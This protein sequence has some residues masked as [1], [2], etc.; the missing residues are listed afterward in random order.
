MLSPPY[1]V[2]AN[3]SFVGANYYNFSVIFLRRFLF[4]SGLLLK[5]LLLKYTIEV[6]QK[7]NIKATSKTVLEH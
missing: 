2:G 1:W 3:N 4:N 6:I 7:E 5:F